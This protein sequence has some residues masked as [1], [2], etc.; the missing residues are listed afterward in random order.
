MEPVWQTGDSA[1]WALLFEVACAPAG[2]YGPWRAREMRTEVTEVTLRRARPGEASLL[3]ELALAAKGHWGYDRAFLESCRAE[4]TFDPDDIA[5]RNIVVAEVA[6]S[7][8]GFYSIDGEPPA[9]ELGNLWVRPNQIGTGLGRVMW[10][11]AMAAAA[12]AGFEYLEIGAEPNALG[13]YRK[14]GA[15]C[16]GETPSESIPGRMLPLMRM[17]VG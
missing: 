17:R 6:G 13:F 9:G 2:R 7:V 15:E 14:V 12:A 16:I 3:S 11:D 1:P 10:R 4:L 8:A 5:R